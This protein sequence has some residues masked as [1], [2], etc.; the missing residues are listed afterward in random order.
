M[1]FLALV[2]AV[3]YM[4]RIVEVE[5]TTFPKIEIEVKINTYFVEGE[6]SDDLVNLVKK[7]QKVVG[8]N[9]SIVLIAD[10]SISYQR[11]LDSMKLLNNSG[12]EQVSLGSKE[13]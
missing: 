9:S 3:F 6:E 2:L 12:F 8:E 4:F 10:K 1:A 7:R 13:K 11:V 5:H